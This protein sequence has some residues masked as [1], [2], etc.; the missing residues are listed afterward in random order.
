MTLVFSMSMSLDGF[1]ADPDGDF[2]WSA[3]DAELHRFHNERVRALSA[4]FMGRRLYETMLYWETD[5]PGW[6]EVEREWADIWRPLPKIVF[7]TT[8]DTVEGNARLAG[9]DVAGELAQFDGDVGI[10]GPGLAASA[11]DVI[12]EY[13]L[14]VNPVVVGGGKPLFPPRRIDLELV[15]TRTFGSRVQYLHY[16]RVE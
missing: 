7:S 1:V 3:P 16:R 8:L 2:S 11:A 13:E 9:G 6:G 4:Q 14:F 15:E 10:G 12:D 5:D